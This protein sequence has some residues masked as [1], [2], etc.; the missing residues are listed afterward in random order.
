[1]KAYATP[2]LFK[3]DLC[4]DCAAKLRTI[5]TSKGEIAMAESLGEVLCGGCLAKVP[6]YEPGR[7]LVAKMKRTPPAPAGEG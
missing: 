3:L 4:H 7:T 5:L 1:M 2:M 6:G